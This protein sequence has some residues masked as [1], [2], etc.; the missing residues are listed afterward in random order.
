MVDGRGRSNLGALLRGDTGMR[1]VNVAISRAKGK[2]VVLAD[3]DW[4]RSA[5]QRADNPLLWDLLMD[6]EAEEVCAVEP[7]L[8]LVAQSG[9]AS[10]ESPIE[11]ALYTAMLNLTE[12]STVVP[13]FIIRD[14]GGTPVSRADFAFP[15][16][17]YAVFCDGKQWHVR[18]DRWQRDWRQAQSADRVGLALHSLYRK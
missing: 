5:F 12:L 6:R 15:E 3:L 7:A 17:K 10:V 14:E 18:V 8:P 9:S 13:Q 1:L 4:C 11:A 2:L 16:L